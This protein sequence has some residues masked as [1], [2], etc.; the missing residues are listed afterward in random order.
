[1]SK[2]QK[3]FTEY[4]PEYIKR[5][6]HNMPESHRKVINAVINCRSG[7]FGVHL[8]KCPDCNDI[9]TANSSCGNRHCPSCQSDKSS[10]W[11]EKQTAKLL[12]CNYFL[13]TFTVPEELR[14]FVR[15]NQIICY[16][17]IFNAASAAM[18][19]LA[20]DKR[21]IGCSISLAERPQS[22]APSGVA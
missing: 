9:H 20:Q 8:Y 4:A 22:G 10:R 5:Y 18:K 19:R 13:V 6:G 15:S 7:R 1:M 3:V 16:N 21:F 11:L 12:P 17:A 14:R 2:I